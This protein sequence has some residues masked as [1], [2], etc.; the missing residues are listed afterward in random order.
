MKLARAPTGDEPFTDEDRHAV[1]EADEW[2][3]SGAVL[4]VV[5]FS[6]RL[7]YTKGSWVF[8][9]GAAPVCVHYACYL[10]SIPFLPKPVT[11]KQGL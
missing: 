2:L 10:R 8:K 4:I 11:T 9:F 6:A 3:K 1:A 5:V 7:M